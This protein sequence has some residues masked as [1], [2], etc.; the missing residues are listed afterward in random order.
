MKNLSEI[1]SNT[2]LPTGTIIRMYGVQRADVIKS[3][4]D[5]ADKDKRNSDFYD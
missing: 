4:S 2:F 3:E 1:E 5:F